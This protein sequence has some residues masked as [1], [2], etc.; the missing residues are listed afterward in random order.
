MKKILLIIFTILFFNISNSQTEKSER[1]Y[2][3]SLELFIANDYDQALILINDA[4][5]S[6]PKW[7]KIYNARGAVYIQ[8]KK[9]DLA[10]LDLNKSI[11]L[12]PNEKAYFNR[13]SVY[14]ELLN[15]DAAL[16]DYDSALE[17]NAYSAKVYR[18]RGF[19]YTELKKYDL[20]LTDFN[21]LIA[22]EPNEEG[23]LDRGLFNQTISNIDAALKDYNQAIRL[24]PKSAQAY[25]Y[26]G[27]LYAQHE[28]YDLALSDFNKLIELKP[29]G[30]SYNFRGNVYAQL[31]KYD[32]ALFDLN[33]SIELESSE[34]AYNCRASI[35]FELEKYDLALL[36]LNKSIELEPDN[37]GYLLRGLVYEKLLNIE[38]AIKDYSSALQLNPKSAEVYNARGLLYI[39]LKKYD[40]ALLDFNKL[41]ELEPDEEAYINRGLVY[42][43]LFNTDSALM[44]YSRAIKL[45]PKSV[46]SHLARGLMN[47]ELKKYDL[48]LLDFNNLIE[49]EPNE[50][51]YLNRGLVYENLLNKD[52]A[53]NDYASVIKLNPKSATA[54]YRIA[55][56]RYDSKNF[57]GANQA[58]EKAIGI[59][60]DS[61]FLE[62]KNKV[63]IDLLKTLDLDIRDLNDNVYHT[64]KIGNQIWL[65]RNLNVRC[66][67]NGDTIKELKTKD[68]WVAAYESGTPGWCY[69][70]N[71]P[72]NALTCGK[73]Y[74]KYAIIDPRGLA[75]E[76]FQ[77]PTKSDWEIL[78]Q[79]LQPEITEMEKKIKETDDQGIDTEELNEKLRLMEENPSYAAGYKLISDTSLITCQ[80]KS[81]ML[82][83][84]GIDLIFDPQ[85]KY[86]TSGF[87]CLSCFNRNADGVFE[88]YDNRSSFCSFDGSDFLNISFN[89]FGERYHNVPYS[90]SA[91]DYNY[92]NGFFVRC[93]NEHE[94]EQQDL[95]YFNFNK[96]GY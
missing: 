72:K 33:K 84:Y 12:E 45:N 48:A 62:L 35:Y 34:E 46:K 13:G 75:P 39:D 54:Y 27:S 7:S 94:N 95:M 69:H 83:S 22:L 17:L 71:D 58:I 18:A 74:N 24:N 70:N 66:F 77:I 10:M 1:L 82:K 87:N 29:N 92:D 91:V 42:K 38:A 15:V 90:F 80:K 88:I 86:L 9:Y 60:S 61:L 52:A 43:C 36:D 4:I 67:R 56:L 68:E 25:N 85:K 2:E 63:K 21:K 31:E 79:T 5:K 89:G 57:I 32:L 73:I 49:L 11:D 28:K 23:Y 51:A 14:E 64:V 44:D 30:E 50:E 96:N 78:I 19:L 53:K 93:I 6:S 40:S 47:V 41:I 16:K 81:E 37:E 55:L 76:G 59:K 26:R 8:L 65:S 3:K 20:A